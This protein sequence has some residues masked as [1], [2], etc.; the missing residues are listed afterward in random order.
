MMVEPVWNPISW[1]YNAKSMLLKI[2]LLNNLQ[3][4]RGT[5]KP[6]YKREREREREREIPPV[7]VLP[8]DS[9]YSQAFYDIRTSQSILELV[10]RMY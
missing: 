2:S 4:N 6:V 8:H 1:K 3:I 9:L 10:S 7:K 5:N